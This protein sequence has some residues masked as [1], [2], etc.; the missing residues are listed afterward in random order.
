MKRNPAKGF[1]ILELL[2][3]L[4]I[5]GV[6]SSIAVIQYSNAQAK[7]RDAKRISDIREIE[8]ALNLYFV[9]NNVFPIIP[10]ILEITG[11]DELSQILESKFYISEVPPDPNHPTY[12]Y[13][14]ESNSTGTDYNITFCLET[15]IISSFEKGCDN[16][17]NP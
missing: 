1:T 6:L 2:V 3:V 10:E 13:T 8:K 11:E 5:I 7:S 17:I 14:Y 9:D 15:P 16:I 12:K 4:A